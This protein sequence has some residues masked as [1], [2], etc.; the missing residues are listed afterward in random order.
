HTV[1]HDVDH[2]EGIVALEIKV[3][4]TTPV[5]LYLRASWT[6][7]TQDIL[8]GRFPTGFDHSRTLDQDVRAGR[9]FV[10]D[11]LV[12]PGPSTR[13]NNPLA[14]DT[15][16]D[17]H[18]LA[19]LQHLRRLVNGGKGQ[20]FGARIRIGSTRIPV[21]HVVRLGKL[22]RL[23]PGNKLAPVRQQHASTTLSGG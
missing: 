8:G 9:G 19:R 20:F 5:D 14:I 15:R 12:G 10:A 22:E 1:L 18:T 7:R 23:L 6:V 16:H 2:A 21:I 17:Y 13:W 3:V 4:Q 11:H